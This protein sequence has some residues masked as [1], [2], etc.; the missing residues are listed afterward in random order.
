MTSETSESKGKSKN[1][2][3]ILAG[4]I[5]CLIS[6]IG[7]FRISRD[8][9]KAGVHTIKILSESGYELSMH[10]YVPKTATA[11]NPAPVILAQHGGNNTKDTMTHYALELVRRGYV[12][13]NCDMYGMGDSAFLPDSQ[14]LSAGRGLYDCV[15]FSRT[16]PFVDKNR[17]GLLGYSRGGK[18]ASEALELD[19][20]EAGLIKNIYLLYSDPTYRNTQGYVDVY[21]ARD[22]QLIADKYDDYF[23]SEKAD[24]T[25]VYSND[26]NKYAAN[27]SS[28]AEFIGNNSAQSFLW[29]GTDPAGVPEKRAAGEI[30][31]KTFDGGGTGSRKISVSKGFHSDAK[32]STLVMDDVIGFF[33]RVMPTSLS[34]GTMGYVYILNYVFVLIGIAGIFVFISA[35]AIYFVRETRAFKAAHIGTPQ[36]REI[37]QSSGALWS[38]GLQIAAIVLGVFI[39]WIVNKQ[40]LSSFR[41]PLFR[42]ANPFYFSFVSMLCGMVIILL[43]IVWYKAYGQKNGVSV[44]SL[45]FIIDGTAMRKSVLAA[46]VTVFF[47]ALLILGTT[48]LFN[49][50]YFFG[51]WGLIAFNAQ[52]IPGMLVVLPLFLAYHV[53]VSVSINCFNYTTAFGRNKAVNTLL[54]TLC[55]AL[56]P[57]VIIIYCMALFRI[58][59]WNPM[60]GGL[61][62]AADVVLS[63][64]QILFFTII[65]SRVI[66]LKT[67]NPYLGGFINAALSAMIVWSTCE[68]RIPEASDKYSG[69]PL[70][71][72][73]IIIAFG[74]IIASFAYFAQKAK[75]GA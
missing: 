18:A 35:A 30:Y 73:L 52:R 37:R 19:N 23:F 45:G 63:F 55:C 64:P 13:L 41:D 7:T 70:V 11:E 69:Q 28:P 67:G 68:V 46:C 16:L 62:S 60:F 50:T 2:L 75:K 25:G 22:I 58:T 71:Y 15:K 72:G 61:A 66:Y 38:W 43:G 42:S 1:G 32:F 34:G 56:P 65:S 53:I 49:T 33:N 59:G 54:Q 3:W 4:L 36:V 74:V 29:F 9:G 21:G 48:Y 12:V 24:D 39:Y 57:L 10:V 5:L 47:A 51:L 20:K 26:A 17:I 31:T 14:W 44:K 8:G 40:G 27:L 6:I